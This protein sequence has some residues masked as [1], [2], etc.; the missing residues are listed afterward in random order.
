MTPD[1]YDE[2]KMV[3]KYHWTYMNGT[4]HYDR[5][6]NKHSKTHLFEQQ[7]TV[8]AKTGNKVLC[9]SKEWAKHLRRQMVPGWSLKHVADDKEPSVLDHV[10]LDSLWTLHQLTDKTQQLWTET[11]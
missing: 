11:A 9:E 3:Q 10:L 6:I 4:D 7:L 1:S 5:T 8:W 2:L